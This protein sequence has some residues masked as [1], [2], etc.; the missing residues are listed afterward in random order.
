PPSKKQATSV[1]GAKPHPDADMPWKDDLEVSTVAERGGADPCSRA[2]R[3][4][5]RFHL[6]TRTYADGWAAVAFCKGCNMA[7]DAGVQERK[8]HP[9]VEGEGTDQGRD[10]PRRSFA[11]NRCLVQAGMEQWYGCSGKW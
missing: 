6:Y 11:C 2:I 3:T 4:S 5:R 8:T 9:G 1:N 7:S 10:L